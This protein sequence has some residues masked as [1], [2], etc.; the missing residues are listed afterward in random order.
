MYKFPTA[1]HKD[2]MSK[3]ST[4]VHKDTY[5]Q[6]FLTAVSKDFTSFQQLCTSSES[7]YFC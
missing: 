4:A 2:C 7:L 5:V 6:V 1:V 3:F